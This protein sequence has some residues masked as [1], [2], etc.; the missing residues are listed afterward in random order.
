MIPEFLL[1]KPGQRFDG[2]WLALGESARFSRF[3]APNGLTIAAAVL[4][5]LQAIPLVGVFFGAPL[6]VLMVVVWGIYL[7]VVI[8]LLVALRLRIR[9]SLRRYLVRQGTPIC[10]DCG[11][12]LAG[13]TIEPGRCP[14]CGVD[15]SS[16]AARAWTPPPEASAFPELL[17]FGGTEAALAALAVAYENLGVLHRRRTLLL[18]GLLALVTAVWV[19]VANL[20]C[21]RAGNLLV[22]GAAI[23]W[24]ALLSFLLVAAAWYAYLRRRIRSSL[25][26]QLRRVKSNNPPDA[27]TPPSLFPL[28]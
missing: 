7:T 8:G 28:S 17:K 11:Y 19:C 9:L 12:D 27:P 10:L 3:L 18:G 23:I 20:L 2:M 22:P 15:C 21:D 26:E 16:L 24:S 25:A 1:L 14:E 13:I 4:A 6:W 5:A